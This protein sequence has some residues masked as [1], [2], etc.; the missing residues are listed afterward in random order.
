GGGGSA[1]LGAAVQADWENRQFTGALALNVRK[2]FEFVLQFE[3]TTRNKIAILNDKLTALERK[4]EFL[5][6]QHSSVTAP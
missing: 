4:L 3:S 2:L 5:E 1:N 6:A